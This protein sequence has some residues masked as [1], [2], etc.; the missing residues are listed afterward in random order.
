MKRNYIGISVKEQ[1]NP[2][3]LQLYLQNMKLSKIDKLY[4]NIK[5]TVR[6]KLFSLFLTS[7]PTTVQEHYRTNQT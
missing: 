6:Y 7:F 4:I 1:N 2:H 5:R 3:K